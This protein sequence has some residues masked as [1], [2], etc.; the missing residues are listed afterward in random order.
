MVLGSNPSWPIAEECDNPMPH[1]GDI[2]ERWPEFGEE[3]A[4]FLYS[5][6]G[7]SIREIE[8]FYDG[9]TY[10]HVRNTLQ[11]MGFDT[12]DRNRGP[13]DGLARRLWEEEPDAI[14]EGLDS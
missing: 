3:P 12:S 14:G 2:K 5:D 13:V 11:D 6:L 4:R 8:E 7:W 9:V 1:R 10:N